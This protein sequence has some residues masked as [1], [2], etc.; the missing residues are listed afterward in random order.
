MLIPLA[1]DQ[2][3]SYAVPA[4]LTLKPGDVVQVPLGPRETVGVVWGVGSGVGRQSQARHRQARHAAARPGA[5]E[6]GRLGGLVHAGGQGLGAGAGA[7]AARRRT[8][9][10]GRSSGCR[11][12][13]P[14]PARMTPARARA[15]AAAE[16]GL[17]IAQA[18]AGGGRVGQLAR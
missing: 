14:P 13:G 11:L 8:G 18:G 12:A 3:Y 15:I 4:G 16:G 17:L 2:A 1:L 5:D 10:S 9:R 6:A 7:C